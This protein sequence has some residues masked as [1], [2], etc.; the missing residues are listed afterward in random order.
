MRTI[1]ITAFLF[2]AMLASAQ[3]PAQAKS[4]PDA[5]ASDARLMELMEVM[6]VRS[7][8]ALG[9]DLMKQQWTEIM[10]KDAERRFPTASPEMK[11]ELT[12]LVNE[13]WALIDVNELAKEI[14]PVYR[15]HLSA[16]DVEGLIAYYRSPLGQRMLDKQ[17]LIAEESMRVGA[18]YAE[19]RM[20]TATAKIEERMR[21]L[22][23]K[24]GNSEQKH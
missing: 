1:F 6:R 3:S 7:Q 8:A 17:P 24:Y 19:Q 22:I 5:V 14:L 11:T 23:N 4:A 13:I 21:D 16:S 12:A 9:L 2:V 15:K 20:T 18:A 10:L